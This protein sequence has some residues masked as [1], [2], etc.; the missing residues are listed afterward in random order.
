M[1]KVNKA[2]VIWNDYEVQFDVYDKNHDFIEDFSM[3]RVTAKSAED[4][5]SLTQKNALECWDAEGNY[6][7]LVKVARTLDDVEVAA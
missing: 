4:A 5:V 1:A 7:V 2:P 3:D 6:T